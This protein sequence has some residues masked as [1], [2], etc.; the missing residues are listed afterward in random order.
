MESKVNAEM[1]Q[2]RASTMAEVSE[3]KLRARSELK[4]ARDKA[5]R[6]QEQAAAT[7]ARANQKLIEA[8]ANSAEIHVVHKEP[9][10]EADDS[11]PIVPVNAGTKVADIVLSHSEEH[12]IGESDGGCDS[13]A[14]WE[15]LDDTCFMQG[16]D[17]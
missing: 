3:L 4:S 15:M 6:L 7:L 5:S 1:E 9:K 14:G 13:N 17:W 11:E 8:E 16:D 2:L 12:E 10:L